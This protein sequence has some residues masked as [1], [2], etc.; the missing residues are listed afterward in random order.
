MNGLYFCHS[1]AIAHR[2]LKP[3]NLLIETN[4][5]LRIADFGFAVFDEG[6]N[7]NLWCET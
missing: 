5:N 2:D 7:E 1:N 4:F 6:K 3:E